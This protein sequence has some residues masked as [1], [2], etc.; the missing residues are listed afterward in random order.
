[1]KLDKTAKIT[2]T[3]HIFLVS[4]TRKSATYYEQSLGF[5][6]TNFYGDEFCLTW[7][8]QICIM[9]SQWENAA[10]IKLVST[11]NSS[12]WD[13]YFWVDNVDLLFQ[14]FKNNAAIIAYEPF[15]KDYG[16]REGVVKDLDGYQLAFGQ[17]I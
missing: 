10:D 6:R 8:D 14:E 5:G 2:S 15:D 16:V 3:A 13:A 1:M 7:R 4:N 12:V 9:L 17:L 11:I